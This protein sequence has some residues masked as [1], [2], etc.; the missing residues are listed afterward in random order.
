MVLHWQ[1]YSNDNSRKISNRC[2]R[3]DG[4]SK[5]EWIQHWRKH[6]IVLLV[7]MLSS[8][9]VAVEDVLSLLAASWRCKS[10]LNKGSE[11]EVVLVP[12]PLLMLVP[13]EEGLGSF[14]DRL[15]LEEMLDV[16]AWVTD[17]PIASWGNFL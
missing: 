10:I 11:S 9:F 1:I 16:A 4:S 14:E 6:V 7:R 3:D 17:A 8:H 15:L 13:V 2:T 5:S 12:L